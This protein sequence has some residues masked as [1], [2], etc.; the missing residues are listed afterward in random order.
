[1]S[2]L[3]AVTDAGGRAEAESR[4]RSRAGNLACV[5]LGANLD[6]PVRQVTRAL[7]ELDAIAGATVTRVSS[8][9][10]T[11]P[12]G[13]GDQPD[14]VNAVAELSCTIGPH[15]LLDALQAIENAHGRRRG[16]V[17]WTPR[18]LD[19]DL[20][21]YGNQV[22]ADERLT[23]PHRELANRAFVLVPLNELDSDKVIPGQPP[24]AELLAAI[25]TSGIVPIPPPEAEE[26]FGETGR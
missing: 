19:L 14:Y 2:R 21:L 20:L 4:A 23:V 3:P 10:R 15:A 13:P 6:E 11:P 17:R 12:L 18:T 9:Y 7:K 26:F 25:D 5:G 1:M 24:L 22:I 16:A 8:L